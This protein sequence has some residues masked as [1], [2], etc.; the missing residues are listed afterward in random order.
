MS[1]KNDTA[2]P[3]SLPLTTS[4]SCTSMTVSTPSLSSALDSILIAEPLMELDDHT[5]N[6]NNTFMTDVTAS[7]TTKA[8]LAFQDTDSQIETSLLQRA[9]SLSHSNSAH[10]SDTSVTEPLAKTDIELSTLSLL[11][12]TEISAI[13]ATQNDEQNNDDFDSKIDATKS[14]SSSQEP[15]TSSTSSPTISAATTTIN[16]STLASSTLVTTLQRQQQQQQQDP[17]TMYITGNTTMNSSS[18]VRSPSLSSASGSGTGIG[19]AA[20]TSVSSATTT[21]SGTLVGNGSSANVAG[22]GGVGPVVIGGGSAG[23]MDLK[24]K[25]FLEHNQRL[26]EQLDMHRITVSEASQSLIKFVTTTKDSLLPNLWGN[27]P[28]DPFSKQS[29]GCCS[30]S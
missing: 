14:N 9:N 21:M 24:L 27:A 7:A 29:T 18:S 26:K 10:A 15:L 17:A 4:A 28:S 6:N 8:Q 19:G 30:I 22:N 23:A 13:T 5:D 2:P 20:S 16:N 25:R 3:S 12:P 11:T 1:T